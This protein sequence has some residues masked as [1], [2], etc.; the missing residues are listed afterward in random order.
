M[1]WFQDMEKQLREK[2]PEM[3]E[4]LERD[5]DALR[6]HI[7]ALPSHVF[8][9]LALKDLT[10]RIASETSLL[11]LAEHLLSAA[12]NTG[13]LHTT[14][15]VLR[16]GSG[17]AFKSRVCTSYP[18]DWL[19]TYKA[20]NYQY[21]D[22]V[23]TRALMEN[24]AFEFSDVRGDSP[25]ERAFWADAEDYGIGTEG[26]TIPVHLRC[27]AKLA[28]SFSSDKD[29]ATVSAL[30]RE[31]ESDLKVV[32]AMACEVFA[33]MARDD[34]VTLNTLD[35]DELQ[36]LRLLVTQDD[37]ESAL[38]E[39]G[40]LAAVKA[41]QASILEKLGVSTILQAIALTSLD[42]C[43]D[44]APFVTSDVQHTQARVP[45]PAPS[46]PALSNTGKGE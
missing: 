35:S 7:M 17:A 13:F 27:G 15:F 22:P 28:I 3:D 4:S 34:A 1:H 41:L 37:P 32:A 29:A 14:L 23:L 31:H 18:P 10:A 25:M 40:G 44:D 46:E 2:L 6:C 26:L 9:T 36:F 45:P 11:E 19:K 33:R 8:R 20:R 5:L 30:R 38:D 43:F 42:P 24:A 39:F 12:R 21:V 16:Q